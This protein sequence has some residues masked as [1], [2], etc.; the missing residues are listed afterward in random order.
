MFDLF[1]TEGK[2]K[3]FCC[4]LTFW[5]GS[6]LLVNKYV[7]LPSFVSKH[8]TNDLKNRIISIMHGL[9]IL[10]MTGYH[11]YRDNPTLIQPSTE[12]QHLAILTSC[13]YFLY[14][15]VACHIYGLTDFSLYFHHAM[16][17]IGCAYAEYID[18]STIP[19]SNLFL[20]I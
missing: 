7:K 3:Y 14:D 6:F 9:T 1:T 13:A 19:I 5:T 10:F 4:A 18:N 2:I 17:V 16:C 8:N 12:I 15:T 20:S 11:I